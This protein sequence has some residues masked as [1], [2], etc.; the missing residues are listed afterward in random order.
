MNGL[1]AVMPPISDREM[2]VVDAARAFARDVIEPNSGAWE[3]AGHVPREA[4]REAARGLCR[5][6]V[7]ESM[8]GHGLGM[9]AMALVVEALAA[10]C[11]A[12]AFALTVHNNLA[13]GITRNAST[14]QLE[15]WLPGLIAGEQIGA[16]LLTEPQGGSDAAAMTTTARRDG[17]GWR[18]DG[19]KAW[20]SNG[21][22]ADLL[23]V[24]AQTDAS[25][26]WRGIACFIVEADAPGVIREPAYRLLG[27]HALGTGGFRFERCHIGA[28][29]VLVG[30]G[31]GFKAALAGVDFARITVAAMC[32][33]MLGRSLEV[34]MEH[35]AGRRTFGKI[36]AGAPSRP[37]T[38][39]RRRHGPRGR[40]TADRACRHGAGRWNGPSYPGRRPCQEVRHAG[41]AQPHRRLYAGH[42][43]KR[44]PHRIPTGAPLDRR[45]NGAIS[46]RHHGNSERRNRPR[47][48]PPLPV[49]DRANRSLAGTVSTTARNLL[50]ELFG[51]VQRLTEVVTLEADNQVL[52]PPF[53]K[54]RHVFRNTPREARKRQP[55]ALGTW[56]FGSKAI[57]RDKTWRYR[58][59]S[60]LW[61]RRL[62][63][64]VHVRER[65]T[66]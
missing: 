8:R 28:D 26:G 2:K 13:R 12:S 3:E 39:G 25:A 9:P 64:A 16:F 11:M 58:F 44:L 51:K 6:A 59:S 66:K 27:S 63:V 21:A 35:G 7:P 48:Y 17:R 54:C 1:A 61:A 40:T 47:H 41:G 62:G 36:G 4:F 49:G 20:V 56:Q 24:Y 31:E 10:A 46:G 14:P 19:A 45:Q 23:S 42:G 22:T 15:R 60:G 30:P 43:G 52:Q 33:G 37:V 38:A 18:L 53:A 34:A 55:P 32:C 50:G 29:D 5:L 65:L 57:P